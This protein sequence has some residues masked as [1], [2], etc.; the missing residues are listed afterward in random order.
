MTP[1]GWVAIFRDVMTVVVGVFL[2][3]FDTVWI[4]PPSTLVMGAGLTALGFP[5]FLRIQL[6]TLGKGSKPN[7]DEG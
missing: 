4:H 6:P 7:A 2:L 1:D 3:V 5:V